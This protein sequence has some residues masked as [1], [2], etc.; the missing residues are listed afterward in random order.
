MVVLFLD[1]AE[2]QR[3]YALHHA[4][5]RQLSCRK[6][7][8][9]A[10]MRDVALLET[11]T[12]TSKVALLEKP[13]AISKVAFLENP[14]T[15]HVTLTPQVVLQEKPAAATPAPESVL[16]RA[17]PP[18][19]ATNQITAS[20]SL[21]KCDL[22]TSETKLFMYADDLKR[23]QSMMHRNES[24]LLTSTSKPVEDWLKYNEID[25]EVAGWKCALCVVDEALFLTKQELLF[26]LS[27]FHQ[28]AQVEIA[29][30]S[31]LELLAQI[32]A[33]KLV[34]KYGQLKASSKGAASR[35]PTCSP[36]VPTSP[37]H[38]ATC[39][40]HVSPQSTVTLRYSSFV[41]M[42]QRTCTVSRLPGAHVMPPPTA[43]RMAWVPR[44]VTMVPVVYPT[45]S[46]VRPTPIAV[47]RPV[48]PAVPR[49]MA[50]SVSMFSHVR[51]VS[52]LTGGVTSVQSASQASTLVYKAQ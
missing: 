46:V 36:H 1:R 20:T 11:P 49:S 9:A 26:H 15:P 40:P 7:S 21:T 48:L 28:G 37:P 42:Q 22:C 3:H 16:Q 5:R 44:H 41:S 6:Q 45:V 18:P 39:S 19:R 13:G 35:Q 17:K 4:G 34:F 43:A 50:G 31:L 10:L 23:H 33:L 32:P 47:V 14:A 24:G 8:L 27:C 38:V 25:E 2:L 51:Q 12:T 30:R 52:V 29:A